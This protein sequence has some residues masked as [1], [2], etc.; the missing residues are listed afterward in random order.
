MS[1]LPRVVP[2]LSMAALL[3]AQLGGCI[4]DASFSPGL[5]ID[6]LDHQSG[7]AGFY[8]KLLPWRTVPDDD[9]A[10]FT[11]LVEEVRIPIDDSVEP[12][13]L[14]PSSHYAHMPCR[15]HPEPPPGLP[16]VSAYRM[17]FESGLGAGSLL[18]AYT[19]ELEGRDYLGLNVGVGEYVKTAGFPFLIPTFVLMPYALDED[20]LRIWEPRNLV[21]L[22]VPGIGEVSD[23]PPIVT[24]LDHAVEDAA[25]PEDAMPTMKVSYAFTIDQ[26]LDYHR[27]HGAEPDFTFDEPMV[28]RRAN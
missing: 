22:I 13:V 10:H 11:V 27:Q 1:E 16:F 8:E 26:L 20:Q 7:F 28:F 21:L 12:P 6:T 24:V 19:I 9:G 3:A 4:S 18:Y 15:P 14:D 5:P 25:V 23:P 2:A 17:T